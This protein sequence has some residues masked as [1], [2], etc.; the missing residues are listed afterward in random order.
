[1]PRLL[2]K[3]LLSRLGLLLAAMQDLVL[4][5]PT[6]VGILSNYVKSIFSHDNSIVHYMLKRM[7]ALSPKP[8]REAQAGVALPPSPGTNRILYSQLGSL[9]GVRE[10]SE[11][12]R[13]FDRSRTLHVACSYSRHPK[14]MGWPGL[15]GKA[16]LVCRS[17]LRPDIYYTRCRR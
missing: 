4:R 8:K 1:M 13:P 5:M 9:K 14:L 11:Q 15:S 12:I 10:D 16:G 2:R 17:N 3:D 7:S 6:S